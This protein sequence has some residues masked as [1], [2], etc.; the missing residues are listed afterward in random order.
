MPAPAGRPPELRFGNRSYEERMVDEALAASE[1]PG[2]VLA[3]QVRPPLP[4]IDPWRPRYGYEQRAMGVGDVLALNRLYD[5]RRWAWTGGPHD[6]QGS[7]RMTEFW[8]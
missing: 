4:Q 5:D 1:I 8:F 2:A 7:A 3:E 6:W